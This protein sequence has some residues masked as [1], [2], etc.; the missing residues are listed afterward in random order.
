MGI[1]QT[2]MVTGDGINR[3]FTAW[4]VYGDNSPGSSATASFAVSSNGTASGAGTIN[5]GTTPGSSNWYTPTTTGI[6]N[7]Y[8]VKYTV[9][10]GSASSN[11][12]SSFTLLNTPPSITK[13]AS[14]GSGTCTFKIEI[15]TDSGGTNIV[16][17]STGNVLRYTHT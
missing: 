7:S 6:G 12:A 16:F 10:S 15:A 2:L 11:A 14:A 3:S 17:T 13:T 9:T 8:Y 5:D 1:Q 4:D